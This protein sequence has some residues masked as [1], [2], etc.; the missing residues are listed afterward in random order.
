ME[1]PDNAGHP[2]SPGSG[3]RGD[4]DESSALSGLLWFL[5]SLRK[6]WA[7]IVALVVLCGAISL[8]YSKSL[9]KVYEAGALIEFDPDVIKP[10]GNKA[11][12]MIG[13]SAIWDT[14]QYY[15]TQYK[16]M[17]SDRVL[18]N[19][20]RDLS[21]QNDV[22]FLG[23]KPTQPVPMDDA[24]QMLRGRLT[25]DPV[26]GSRLVYLKV[27][28]S[29]PAQARRLAEAVARAYIQQNLD[30][31]L[32]A[33]SDTVTWLSGQLDHSKQELE[34]TE[35]SLH[36][37]KKQNDLPSSTLEDLS[38][39]IRMEMQ[40][41][42]SALTRTRMRHGELAA[43]HAELAKITADNPDQVPA[44]ELLNN[45][46]LG[47][48]RTQYQNA[49][50]ERAELVAEGKGENHPAV[51]KADEKIALAK[52]SL[53]A[54]VRNIQGAIARDL[55]IIQRQESGEAT[56]LEGARKKAVEL[57][58][59]ELEFHRLDRVRAQ[60]EKLYSVLLEQLKEADL[61]RMMNTNNIRLVDI[62]VEP[63]TPIAPRVAVNVG[64][65]VLAGLVLGMALALLREQLDNS[66]KT[67]QD[68]EEKLGVTFLGLLP[69]IAED[70]NDGPPNGKRRRPRRLETK[71]APEL[72]VHERPTSGAAEAAR[73]L[74]TNLMFMNPD[75]PYRRIL[76][77]SAA[78]SEG[79]TTVAVSVAVSLAQG[80]QRVC[81]VDCDLRRPRLHRIFDRAGDVGVMNV[82]MGESTIA[83]A[84]K[85]TIV[86][87]LYCLPCGPIPP[88]SADVVASEKFRK[89]L[90][91]LSQHFDRIV[92]D[93]PPIVAVTDSAI[94][95]TLTDGVIFVIRA[96][97]TSQALC[98]QGLRAL[99]D[100][101]API[102]GA[103]LNAVNLNRHEYN[104]HHYYYYKREGYA[105]LVG[106][107]A[108][109]T[110]AMDDERPASPPN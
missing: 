25:V 86:P 47:G 51:K 44:S 90:D 59:K 82:I 15:E 2:A 88:N 106:S 55:A 65:A 104:Y 6:H 66:L 20:I 87:N 68:V 14:Q 94:V 7:L 73:T 21:L 61:R 37:F 89:L 108:G 81:I 69:E 42:D 29:H 32:N 75:R 43:R 8:A 36:E 54:E 35:Y 96:F 10:L 4:S 92:L 52:N 48:L 33:T 31:M 79:K 91:D 64:V 77:T 19:V 103:V 12:P 72:L 53:L 1:Q 67:P 78:P 76:V 34:Q 80:G 9:P 99:R 95:S 30:K 24:V 83:E 93:S 46:F 50:R 16:L 102:A 57:N 17:T 58:L 63:K 56:L 3:G 97:R 27:Q 38:K 18:S 45:A 98:R 41:Y 26:K 70:E 107:G 62:P 109:H 84:A 85:P 105:P 39:M 23:Y 49:V 13:W 22:D 110:H 101:D 71:L 100:V 5:R 60:S 28:D 11:D 74:R 40:E